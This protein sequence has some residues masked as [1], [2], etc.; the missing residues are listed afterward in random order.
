[1]GIVN[2]VVPAAELEPTALAVARHLAAIDP[3]LVR[4][5]KRS[6][7]RS[8]EARGMVGALERL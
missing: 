8:F 2:R 6:I 4:R 5:T 1:M 3:E 7:N